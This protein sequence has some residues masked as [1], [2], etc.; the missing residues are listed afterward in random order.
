[1][2]YAWIF[3]G[4]GSQHV[5]MA[6]T[7]VEASEAARH[8][9]EEADDQ[10]GFSLSSLCREGPLEVLTSTENAQ[11]ALLTHSVAVL[12]AAKEA[13]GRPAMAAGHSLGEFSAY[14]AAD[15]LTFAQALHAVRTRGLLMAEAGQERPG[16]MAAVIG[17]D[18]AQVESICDEVSTDAS[19]CVPANY[20]SEGQIVV[21]GDVDA[22]ERG[23]EAMKAAGARR[24]LPLQVSGA[25]HSPLMRAA[26]SRFATTLEGIEFRDPEFPV[27]SNV[28][29]GPITD[30]ATARSRLIEQLTS[31][32]RWT[33]SIEYMAGEG[34]EGFVEIGPGKVLSGLVRRI[35]KGTPSQTVGEADDLNALLAPNSTEG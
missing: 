35:A 30:G 29:A 13:L 17:L 22:V 14:V 34:I 25:F 21:S 28:T 23:I 33:Q 8:V 16:T 31:P 7:L 24:A 27:V 12:A 26:Q 15:T 6:T 3:P 9:F 11:P 19:V 18:T 1:M 32:V 2:S 4:Q 5:G 20:N 10:L